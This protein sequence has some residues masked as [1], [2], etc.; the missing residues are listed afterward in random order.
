MALPLT[1]RLPF[2]PDANNPNNYV[3]GEEHTLTNRPRRLIK[4]KYGSYYTKSLQVYDVTTNTLLKRGV[5][6][7]CTDPR[8]TA[9][10]KTGHEACSFIV[11]TN[12]EVSPKIKINYQAVGGYYSFISDL[13]PGL[14]D[15]LENDNRVVYYKDIVGKPKYF[16]PT[17]HL[18]LICD[19]YGF[20]FEVD[21]INNLAE[22]VAMGDAAK[23]QMYLDCRRSLTGSFC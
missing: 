9:V 22:I 20:E 16:N 1:V 23:M 21:A 8:T 15:R 3:A 18:H 2:D 11:I 7:I 12:T 5:D 14:I 17:H 6:Y 4:P 19:V 10:A 13:L